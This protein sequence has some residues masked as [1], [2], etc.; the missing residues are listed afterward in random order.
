MGVSDFYWDLLLYISD[1]L[2]VCIE[3]CFFYRF[4]KPFMPG[5]RHVG[6]VGIVYIA[7]MM[8]LY[9]SPGAYGGS[10]Y[11]AIGAAAVFAVMYFIDKRNIEQKIFLALT[12]YLVKWITWGMA[13]VFWNIGVYLSLM[14]PAVQNSLTVQFEVYMIM[15]ICSLV[16]E[17]LFM[18]GVVRLMHR[19]YVYK[20]ENMTK[21]ELV[22]ILMPTLSLISGRLLFKYFNNVYEMDLKQYIWDNHHS[23][24]LVLFLYHVISLAALLTVIII[25]QRIKESRRNEME[26]A[27]LARQIEDMESHI[28]E[29]EKLYHDIRSLKHDMANHVMV[30]E[31]LY[32]DNAEAGE[33]TAQLKEQIYD[34]V[35]SEKVKS[36]NPVTDVILAEKQK[37]AEKGEIAFKN[38]FHCPENRKLNAFDV[39]VILNNALNNAIEAAGECE[40]PYVHISSYLKNNAY[41]IKIRN[42]VTGIKTID[43][44]S[45]LP[46][47]T[48]TDGMHGF[49]L[50][51]I[52]KVAQRYYG[53][54]DIEQDGKE[55]TLTVMLL[56]SS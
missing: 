4:V 20:M 36:G 2:E 54:I 41:M 7:V 38:D 31:K 16:L 21:R 5:K 52:R 13:I 35:L 6:L 8:I 15:Q 26:E 27:I 29:V 11:D 50:S 12:F 34:T 18:A 49:G 56:L 55:F 48:K 28:S 37:E 43:E 30:L 17:C 47:T 53:D 51:N 44:E 42:S 23:Y 40:E 24:H 22:L 1:T 32:G 14:I 19:A 33:Y 46:V 10:V 9:I 45:G 3:G 25:Y 39:S